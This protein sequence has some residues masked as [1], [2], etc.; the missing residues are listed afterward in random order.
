MTNDIFRQQLS[1]SFTLGLYAL[2]VALV[3]GVPFGILAALR[4]NSFCDHNS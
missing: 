3:V 2:A 4:Q 1:V